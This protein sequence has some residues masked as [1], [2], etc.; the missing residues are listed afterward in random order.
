MKELPIA[1]SL[2][3]GDLGER[4][5]KIEAIGA[6]ALLSHDRISGT[7]RLR[8]RLD[9]EVQARLES[10]VAAEKECCP[11]LDIALEREDEALVLSIAAPTGAEPVAAELA[12][13][14]IQGAK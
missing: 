2:A 12:G 10:I 3:A 1:C 9:S 8:F 4:L 5:V 14:F 7:H 13:A 11:F 6:A